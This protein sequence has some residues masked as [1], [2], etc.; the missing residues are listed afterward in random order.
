MYTML[1]NAMQCYAT[2]RNAMQR[3]VTLRNVTH[4][5]TVQCYATLLKLRNS[6]QRYELRSVARPYV[7]LRNIA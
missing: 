4:C 3:Y 7:K 5:Y 6:T 2:L 1:W